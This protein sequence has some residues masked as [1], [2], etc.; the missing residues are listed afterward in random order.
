MAIIWRRMTAVLNPDPTPLR[1]HRSSFDR[2]NVVCLAWAG[3]FAVA[4]AVLALVLQ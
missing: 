3:V 1:R 2:L 4:T